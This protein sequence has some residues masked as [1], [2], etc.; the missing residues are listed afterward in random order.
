[1][2]MEGKAAVVVVEGG[3]EDQGMLIVSEIGKQTY[4]CLQ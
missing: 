2:V 1:M 3:K 4:T